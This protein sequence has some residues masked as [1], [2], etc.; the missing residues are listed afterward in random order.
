MPPRKRARWGRLWRLWRAAR[1][2]AEGAVA[3]D[4][5]PIA[6][7]APPAIS[8][9]QNK[10]SGLSVDEATKRAPKVEIYVEDGD[11]MMASRP[12]GLH[13]E[14]SFA[15]ARTPYWKARQAEERKGGVF[16]EVAGRALQTHADLVKLEKETT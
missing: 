4:V 3:T 8:Y 1:R 2:M 12:R 16:K 14:E 13:L 11:R 10:Y 15:T 5:V 9:R 6:A 7:P